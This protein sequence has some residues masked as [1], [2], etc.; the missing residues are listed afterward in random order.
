MKNSE[1]V[2][3]HNNKIVKLILNIPLY[4]APFYKKILINSFKWIAQFIY[5]I[6]NNLTISHLSLNKFQYF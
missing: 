5:D 1:W 2:V 3:L 4:Q 6:F